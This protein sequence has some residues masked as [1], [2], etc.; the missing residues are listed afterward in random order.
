VLPF[1]IHQV[2]GRR[3]IN[4]RVICDSA[5]IFHLCLS[6]LRIPTPA[7]LQDP[8]GVAES[9]CTNHANATE[10]NKLGGSAQIFPL[11]T[12]RCNQ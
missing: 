4:C 8:S 9:L 11:Q 3:T 1:K 2:I 10:L 6:G 7:T 12:N 5:L